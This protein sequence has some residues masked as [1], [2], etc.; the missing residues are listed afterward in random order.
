MAS[1]IL[2]VRL[3]R[4]PVGVSRWPH[5]LRERQ[6]FIQRRCR[7]SGESLAASISASATW[8]PRVAGALAGGLP[9]IDSGVG[10]I[11][12][13]D[14]TDCGVAGVGVVVAGVAGAGD[15][16]DRGALGVGVAGAM[17]F[18][19]AAAFFGAFPAVFGVVAA[20]VALPS[21]LDCCTMV[22][23]FL[24]NSARL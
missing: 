14:A 1:G 10:G 23:F 3:A 21:G 24:K 16:D 18:F 12:I 4:W 20:A 2:D 17:A 7:S 11:V 15:A 9:K 5:R 8:T 6:Y 19:G 13:E 22:G